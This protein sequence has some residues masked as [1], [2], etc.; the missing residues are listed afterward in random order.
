MTDGLTASD[1][2]CSSRAFGSGVLKSYNSVDCHYTCTSVFTGEWGKVS[3]VG[4]RQYRGVGDRTF[5]L[6]GGSCFIFSLS[7]ML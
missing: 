6:L 1:H 4:V 5:T 7:Y 2:N 3:E